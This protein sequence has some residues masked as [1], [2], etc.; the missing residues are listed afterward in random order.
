MNLVVVLRIVFL[1]HQGSMERHLVAKIIPCKQ[2][3]PL[4]LSLSIP[5]GMYMSSY[6]ITVLVEDNGQQVRIVSCTAMP[7]SQC[8]AIISKELL[9]TTIILTVLVYAS[10]YVNFSRNLA[11][12]ASYNEE[13]PEWAHYTTACVGLASLAFPLMGTQLMSNLDD[14]KEDMV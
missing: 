5:C 2:T 8:S 12:I 13:F 14:R 9:S 10:A 6:M 4:D 7:Q 3:H 11:M 1:V